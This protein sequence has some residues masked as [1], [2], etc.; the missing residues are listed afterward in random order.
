MNMPIGPTLLAPLALMLAGGFPARAC[1]EDSN[2][3]SFRGPNALG[4]TKNA[5]PPTRWNVETGKNIKWKTAIPGLGLSSPIVW[6]GR[7]FLTTAVREDG[8]Q[9]LKVGLYGDIKPVDDESSYRWQVLCLDKDTGSILWEQTACQG[10]PKVKR[11]TKASH[12][13]STPATDG[14]HV[15]AFFGSEGLY[16]YDVEGK[17]I[18]KKDLGFLDSGYYVV[19]E[20]QWGFGSSPIIFDGKVYVQCDVQKNSFLAAYDVKDG[21]EL[22]RAPRDEVPTWSTPAICCYKDRVQLV[23]NGYKHI[24]GYDALTGKEVWNIRGGGDIPVP[25]P[26]VKGGLIY[27]TNAHGSMAPIYAIRASASGDITPSGDG[28]QGEHVAWWGARIGN[29]MQTP[30]VYRKRLYSCL[31]NGVLT[32]FDA[33]T[34]ER[35]YRGRLG[36]GVSGFTASGV[37]AAG[38]LYYTSEDGEVHVVKAGEKFK[39]LAVNDMDEVCMATPAISGNTLFIRGQKHLFAIAEAASAPYTADGSRPPAPG[40]FDK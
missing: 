12:A 28:G 3:P 31:D 25:T 7:L 22:W 27:I 30:L 10:V 29:Y 9:D 8:E 20:A 32:C 21:R 6:G 36:K 17:L 23:V 2:W 18:W 5:K 1:A 16:C 26:I 4:V 37:A 39:P 35:L 40:R 34:G 14:K 11:H 24:G 13:N 38:R 15:V 19:P 33:V